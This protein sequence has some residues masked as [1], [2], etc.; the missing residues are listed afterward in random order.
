MSAP[1]L[2][3]IVR[4]VP[5]GADTTDDRDRLLANTTAIFAGTPESNARPEVAAKLAGIDQ[6]ARTWPGRINPGSQGLITG[7]PLGTNDANLNTAYQHLYEIALAT[8]TPGGGL[9][10]D[11]AAQQRVMA[12]MPAR[13]RS[14]VSRHRLQ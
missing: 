3:A 13:T 7:M 2:L 11:T 4:P 1:A 6:T 9:E 12:P 8:R 10:G 14:S 5:A